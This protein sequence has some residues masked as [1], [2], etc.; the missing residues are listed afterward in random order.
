VGTDT[1]V[2][3]A[4]LFERD[5]VDELDD[6]SQLP[7]LGRS[8]VLWI[9]LDSP[10]EAE[11]G[12]LAEVFD[13]H[14]E[15]RASLLDLP[16]EPAL[17]DYHEYLQV[18]A[19]AP[20][21]DERSLV[22]VTCLV[23]KRWLVTAHAGRLEVLETFRER[24]A[25]SGDTGRIE[26]PEFLANVLEWVFASYYG[27]FEDVE[28]VLEEIDASSMAGDLDGKDQA[29]T[30]LARRGPTRDRKAAACAHIPPRAGPLARSTRARWN[31]ELI[32]LGAVRDASSTA[33]GGGPGGSGQPRVGGRLLRHRAREHGSA[34]E[35]DHEG[36]H[37]RIG[38]HPP[39][40]PPGG[41]HGG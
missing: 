11:V 28:L 30:R 31:H 4:L 27:A 18:T 7:R 17:R 23:S 35:R 3:T 9:D 32:R 40:D 8:T 15:T 12:R 1:A 14:E 39:G 41:D 37:P 5:S 19:C 16:E 25:A 13:L 33:R 34:H 22:A 20:A 36:P 2:A 38:P 10:D 29:L 21:D 6:W 26:A 24:A